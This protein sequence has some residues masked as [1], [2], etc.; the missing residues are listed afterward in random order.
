MVNTLASASIPNYS[1]YLK[2]PVKTS[3]RDKTA[4]VTH[5]GLYLF[6]R[7]PLGLTNAPAT[8]QRTLDILFAPFKGCSCLVY[9]DDIYLN[10][11]DS[12]FETVGTILD[13][14]SKASISL[15][16]P[17]CDWFTDKVKYLGHLIRP[18]SLKV[19]DNSIRALKLA[20]HRRNHTELRAFL[21]L[22]NV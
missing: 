13:A 16:L 9:L 10:D 5:A 4:F 18:G 6:R 12:D 1:G 11:Y 20:K 14:L 19:D 15:K 2:L 8:V 7:M 3:D 21:G 22:C 17:K